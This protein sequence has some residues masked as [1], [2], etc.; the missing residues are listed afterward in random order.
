MRF[1]GDSMRDPAAATQET[2]ENSNKIKKFKISKAQKA[3][4]GFFN[5]D[6]GS[7]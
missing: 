5:P 1:G 7:Q 4:Q 3:E 6:D 2:Q